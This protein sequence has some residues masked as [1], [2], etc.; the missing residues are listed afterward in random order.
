MKKLFLSAII[1]ASGVLGLG[2][3]TAS[4]QQNYDYRAGVYD[5]GPDRSDIRRGD[6][7]Y[8]QAE[9]G[10]RNGYRGRGSRVLNRQVFDTRHRAR[11]VLIEEVRRGRRGPR[12]VCTVSARG[13]QAH[14]VS[15]RRMFRIAN[16]NCSPRAR[17]RVV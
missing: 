13:P 15:E 12:L 10:R 9:Y 11:I 6:R 7:G 4:A 8:S 1:A 14:R 5:A 17:V 3:T 2:V 16:R